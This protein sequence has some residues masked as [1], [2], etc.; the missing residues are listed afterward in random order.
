MR[1]RLSFELFLGFR[2]EEAVPDHTTLW[3]FRVST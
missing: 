2:L 3:L 1:N